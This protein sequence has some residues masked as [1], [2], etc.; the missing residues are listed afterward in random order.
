MKLYTLNNFQTLVVDYS[1]PR[2][3]AG[4]RIWE[5]ID[6]VILNDRLMH[7]LGEEALE[8]AEDHR[9]EKIDENQV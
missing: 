6:I 9:K 2:N 7:V 1:S 5:N 4:T 3:Y 8:G